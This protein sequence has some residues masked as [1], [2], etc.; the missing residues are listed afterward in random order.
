MTKEQAI[1]LLGKVKWQKIG[2]SLISDGG[3]NPGLWEVKFDERT[4]QIEITC[5]SGGAV[6]TFKVP[7][8]P[9]D[10]NPKYGKLDKEDPLYKALL[11]VGNKLEKTRIKKQ[12]DLETRALIESGIIKQPKGVE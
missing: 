1:L 9:D 7:R 2:Q 5:Y 11:E 8:V 4:E 12:Q 6:S 10:V 3:M